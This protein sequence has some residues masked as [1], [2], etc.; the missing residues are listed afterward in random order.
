MTSKCHLQTLLHTTMPV[1]IQYRRI[2]PVHDTEEGARGQA[3]VHMVK[4]EG[5]N[6]TRVPVIFKKT[7]QARHREIV[8]E[9]VDDS[10][11]EVHGNEGWIGN[12]ERM[13]EANEW[14]ED[15]SENK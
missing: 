3:K 2:R 5:W 4:K 12:Y 9:R 1:A 7:V 13:S 10:C 11:I 15:I 6:D 14:S 8:P